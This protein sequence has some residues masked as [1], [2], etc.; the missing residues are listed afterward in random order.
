[1]KLLMKAC[2]ISMNE[3]IIKLMPRVIRYFDKIT[4]D[5][6]GEITLI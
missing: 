6:V 2:L 5:F 4:E 3:K 1:M